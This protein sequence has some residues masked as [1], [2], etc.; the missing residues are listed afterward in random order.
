MKCSLNAKVCGGAEKLH[1]LFK[2]AE[3]INIVRKLVNGQKTSKSKK[4]ETEMLLVQMKK[5][6]NMGC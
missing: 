6:V 4:R 3:S 5:S 1:L 2:I